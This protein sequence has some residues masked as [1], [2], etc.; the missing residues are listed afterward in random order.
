MG[1]QEIRLATELRISRVLRL[2]ERMPGT[3]TAHSCRKLDR[4][5]LAKPTASFATVLVP[6]DDV[7]AVHDDRRMAGQPDR[8]RLCLLET[9]IEEHRVLPGQPPFQFPRRHVGA[10]GTNPLH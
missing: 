1:T 6:L 5:T 3:V 4:F 10:A 9:R 7:R 2:T 8:S